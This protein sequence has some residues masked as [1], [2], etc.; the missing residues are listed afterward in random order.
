MRSAADDQLEHSLL[1]HQAEIEEN[2]A[3]AAF[4][5]DRLAVTSDARVDAPQFLRAI[6]M[7]SFIDALP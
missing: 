5:G 3:I 1:A 6:G 7:S 4:V 2:A